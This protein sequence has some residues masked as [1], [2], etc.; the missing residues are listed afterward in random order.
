MD[1]AGICRPFFM[2]RSERTYPT[3]HVAG[4]PRRQTFVNA[5]RT[6]VVIAK[7]FANPI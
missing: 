5:L 4:K 2:A 1:K 6:T 7:H 3:R